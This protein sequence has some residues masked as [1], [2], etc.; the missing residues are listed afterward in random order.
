MVCAV[1]VGRR[2]TKSEWALTVG[3]VGWGLPLGVAE[4]R[5]R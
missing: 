4:G 1:Q 5:M 2:T 3:L